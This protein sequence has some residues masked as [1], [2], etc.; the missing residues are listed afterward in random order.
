[1]ILYCIMA[2]PNCIINENIF[3]QRRKM[4]LLNIPPTRY[5]PISP[6]PQFTQFQL[7]MRRKVEI[8]K[9]SASNTN[10]KT[11]NFTKSGNNWLVAIISEEQF[12][13][14]ILQIV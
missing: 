6:Y 14:M 3:N 10:S 8:L 12:L 5:T 11:N 4:Q 7:N 9:Y 13:N 1:M 2:D